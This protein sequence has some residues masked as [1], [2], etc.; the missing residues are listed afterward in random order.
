M[1]TRV[2][3]VRLMKIPPDVETVGTV[4]ESPTTLATITGMIPR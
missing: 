3:K 4:V 1:K 2:A